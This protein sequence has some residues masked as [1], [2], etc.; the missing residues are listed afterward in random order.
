[1]KDNEIIKALDRLK[2]TKDFLRELYQE[3]V[4]KCPYPELKPLAKQT[5]EDNKNAFNIAIKA[6]E[7]NTRQKAKIAVL[8]VEN[9]NLK[10][11]VEDLKADKSF[12]TEAIASGDAPP[13]I[14][15]RLI[16][17]NNEEH[18]NIV[19][20]LKA[21]IEELQLKKSELKIELKAMRGAANSYKAEIERLTKTVEE[22]HEGFLIAMEVY[23]NKAIKEFAE[24]LVDEKFSNYYKTDEILVY[25]IRDRIC[26]FAESY[27][28]RTGDRL[29]VLSMDGHKSLGDVD[30]IR[31]ESMLL[32]IKNY[33]YDLVE[34]AQD[35]GT[36]E[37]DIQAINDCAFELIAKIKEMV[38][39]KDA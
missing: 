5:Y 30:R 9:A 18:M 13:P 3:Q 38:G 22:Q 33:Q 19:N 34:K 16:Q 28:N 24:E 26:E 2:K 35:N 39:D 15:S 31:A 21:E 4:K 29:N 11:C 8:S 12:L 23:K 1:M 6:I 17:K 7:E 10:I 14:V 27:I 37:V 20:G 36:G 25:D 32:A